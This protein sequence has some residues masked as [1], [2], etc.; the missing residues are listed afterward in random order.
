MCIY[1]YTCVYMNIHVYICIYMCIY[2]YTYVYMLYNIQHKYIS[3]EMAD[4]YIFI[5]AFLAGVAGDDLCLAIF[6]VLLLF[7]VG[8][9]RSHAKSRK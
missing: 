5:G 8:S 1:V 7:T 6:A 9:D 4:I 2:V 3:V